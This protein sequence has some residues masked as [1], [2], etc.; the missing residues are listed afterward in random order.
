MPYF[1][2]QEAIASEISVRE[3]E[4][5]IIEGVYDETTATTTGG[6]QNDIRNCQSIIQNA[7]NFEA[8]LGTDLWKE[9]CSFRRED[10]YTNSNYISDG[11]NNAQLL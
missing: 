1:Q 9:F 8:Y 7:L 4:L 2:K 5:T 6:L 3:N 10:K 11:L